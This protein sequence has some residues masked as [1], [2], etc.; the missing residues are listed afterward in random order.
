MHKESIPWDIDHRSMAERGAWFLICWGMV[1]KLL[2]FIH[3]GVCSANTLS[4][5]LAGESQS[6]KGDH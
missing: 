5:T 1:L 3:A 6:E 2:L 4:S